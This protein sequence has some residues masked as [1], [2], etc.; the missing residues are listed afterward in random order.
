MG[1]IT[2]INQNA[3]INNENSQQDAA[4]V[5]VEKL[6]GQ[7]NAL[8]ANFPAYSNPPSAAWLAAKKELISIETKIEG[9]FSVMGFQQDA[10]EQC[11]IHGWNKQSLPY[12]GTLLNHILASASNLLNGETP[13]QNFEGAAMYM[14]ELLTSLH[15]EMTSAPPS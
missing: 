9:Q 15:N 12:Y 1:S 13:P 2:A 8:L 11:R 5:I 6:M 7:L 4:T 10:S 14:N 3:Y